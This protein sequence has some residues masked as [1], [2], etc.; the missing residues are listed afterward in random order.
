[1]RERERLGDRGVKSILTLVS[2]TIETC[3]WNP[4]ALKCERQPS[5]LEKEKKTGD[6]MRV[7]CTCTCAWQRPVKV[8]FQTRTWARV[9]TFGLSDS[10][11]YLQRGNPSCCFLPHNVPWCLPQSWHAWSHSA[12]SATKT[13]PAYNTNVSEK[14]EKKTP[15][16]KTLEWISMWCFVAEASRGLW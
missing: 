16:N 1:M 5:S 8:N 13:Q 2:V 4:P 6:L 11:N 9:K 12:W 3:E 14:M 7:K 15:Q 10:S